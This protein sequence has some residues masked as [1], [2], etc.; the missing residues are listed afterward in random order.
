MT[1]KSKTTPKTNLVW[2]PYPETKP[3]ISHGTFL[4]AYEKVIY[5]GKGEKYGIE[6]AE[7][8]INDFI[9]PFKIRL[10]DPRPAVEYYAYI[11]QPN[12]V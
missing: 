12:E 3:D 4:T 10:S 1:Q 7:W 5:N 8:V 9:I 6:V 2:F 11:T